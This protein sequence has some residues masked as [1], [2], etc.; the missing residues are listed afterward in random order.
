MTKH[1]FSFLFGKQI[2]I[3]HKAIMRK[4]GTILQ[5]MMH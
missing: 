4:F 5:Q 3:T 2:L 1:F